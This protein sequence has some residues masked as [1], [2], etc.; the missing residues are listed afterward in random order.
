MTVD[1]TSNLWTPIRGQD[2]EAIL[3]S[4]DAG[5][6]ETIDGLGTIRAKIARYEDVEAS[7]S[8][9]DIDLAPGQTIPSHSNEANERV[10]ICYAGTGRVWSNGEEHVVAQGALMFWGRGTYVSLAQEGDEPFR[11]SVISLV[12]DAADAD[13]LFPVNRSVLTV[14][15][16][17]AAASND[18]NGF[19]IEQEQEGEQYWQAAPS[20]GFITLKFGEKLPVDYFSA[21]SQT[22]DADAFVRLH[23]HAQS[24]EI[25]V[26]TRG[27]GLAVIGEVEQD[28]AEGDLLILPP[29]VTHR[30]INDSGEP[31]TYSGL[32][33]PPSVE[34]ALRET[35]VR[36]LPGAERPAAIPRNPSTER[37]LVEKYGFIIPSLQ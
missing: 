11:L 5:A 4:A 37:L 8:V 24:T 22:L 14:A 15:D 32:F 33:T 1:K 3:L 13:C 18:G 28:F 20:L 6:V 10:A 23:G 16:Q 2:R 19:L 12:P 30:F 36:K 25:V 17:E 34:S 31:W 29:G 35:G 27:R 26:C 9:I 21:S 7:F